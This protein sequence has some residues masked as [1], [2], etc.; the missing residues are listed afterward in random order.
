MISTIYYIAAFRSR[1][2]TTRLFQ[3]A[4]NNGIPC[5]VIDTPRAA[6][7]GCGISVRYCPEYHRRICDIYKRE[8]Y[9]SLIGFFKTE[10]T[11][12]GRMIVTPL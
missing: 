3:S 12:G 11:S 4:K 1:S 7:A 9:N 5:S 6:G 10:K 2:Q 8:G